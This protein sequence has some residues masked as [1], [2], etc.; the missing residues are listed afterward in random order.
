MQLECRFGVVDAA[1][2]DVGS[3]ERHLVIARRRHVEDGAEKSAY[4]S[5]IDMVRSLHDK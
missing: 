3:G 2:H 5:Q 1:C 4:L